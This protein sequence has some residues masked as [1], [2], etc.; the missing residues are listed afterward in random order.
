MSGN[1]E[2]RDLRPELFTGRCC[3]DVDLYPFKCPNCGRIM[4]F[5]SECGTLYEDP[6][7]LDRNSRDSVNH[8]EPDQPAFKCPGCAREFEYS[9]MKNSDYHVT[10]AEFEEARLESLLRDDISSSSS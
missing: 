2:E 9:F 7:D 3:Y 1:V 10:R 6:H 4:V 8:F 5:C